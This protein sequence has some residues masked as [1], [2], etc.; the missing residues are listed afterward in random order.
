MQQPLSSQSL[1]EHKIMNL[2]TYEMIGITWLLQHYSE[3]EE[4][5]VTQPTNKKT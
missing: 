3:I 1:M 5:V 4:N 2:F